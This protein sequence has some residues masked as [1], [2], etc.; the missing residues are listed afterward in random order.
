[1]RTNW[2]N[3]VTKIN[4]K[5]YAWPAGWETREE[6]AEQLECSPERVSE[7]LAPGIRSGDVEKGTFAVWDDHLNRKVM[8]T[9]YRM[10]P[11]AGS[12]PTP[13][14]A[15]PRLPRPTTASGRGPGRPPVKYTPPAAGTRVRSRKRG[16]LGTVRPD[17][18]IDWDS[19]NTS[20][21]GPSTMR[22]DI[23]V[24]DNGQ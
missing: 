11:A 1:M 10:R 18:G 4:R 2:K 16:T 12:T 5:Q 13:E 8:I 20:Y 19:G 15:Q 22:D 21:P 3:V 14:P 7:I 6:V 17:G 23:R 24:V 9:G